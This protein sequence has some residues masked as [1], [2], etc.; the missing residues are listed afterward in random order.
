VREGVEK[1][2]REILLAEDADSTQALAAAAAWTRSDDLCPSGGDDLTWR[3]SSSAGRRQ[4][5]SRIRRRCSRHDPRA[6]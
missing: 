3:F 4:R 6:C 5:N 1:N 2:L